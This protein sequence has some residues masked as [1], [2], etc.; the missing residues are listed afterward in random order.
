MQLKVNPFYYALK[1][2]IIDTWY[3]FMPCIMVNLFYLL[4][5]LLNLYLF[6]VTTY[7][8]YIFYFIVIFLTSLTFIFHN[9]FHMRGE[10]GR[11]VSK[12]V[13]LTLCVTINLVIYSI[14]YFAM[15]FLSY[16]NGVS[17]SVLYYFGVILT[18]LIF[19]I[20]LNSMLLILLHDCT[21]AESYFNSFIILFSSPFRVIIATLIF[22]LIIA[23]GVIFLSGISSGL[24]FIKD[25]INCLYI[26]LLDDN[27]MKADFDADYKNI[28]KFKLSDLFIPR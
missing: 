4:I 26:K 21:L 7:N 6:Q 28:V 12:T 3:N 19:I 2:S 11:N 13:K 27:G 15:L 25:F 23:S 10:Y 5:M 14:V 9:F 20:L 22:L 17:G 18:I 24:L 1:K 16:V 8:S